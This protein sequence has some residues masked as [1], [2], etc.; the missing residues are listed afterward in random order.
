MD[1]ND[2]I[3]KI[4]GEVE[5]IE[6]LIKSLKDLNLENLPESR[7][8]AIFNGVENAAYKL[9]TSSMAWGGFKNDG[10]ER[11]NKKQN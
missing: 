7:L 6:Y 4:N 5:K 8:Q 1:K 3:N 2:L 9:L 11:K 10:F